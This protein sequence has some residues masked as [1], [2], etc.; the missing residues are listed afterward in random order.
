MEY[1]IIYG[2]I[3]FLCFAF[4]IFQKSSGVFLFLLAEYVLIGVISIICIY[5]GYV[6][7]ADIQLW[8]YLFLIIIYCI[9]LIPFKSLN[10]QKHKLVINCDD[11]IMRFFVLV[12]I[13]MSIIAVYVLWPYV[14]SLLVSKEWNTN[15][16]YL[17]TN[18]VAIVNN[19][20]EWVAINF[21]SYLQI[22]ALIVAF[23]FV[24]LNKYRTLRK[25]LF[26]SITTTVSMKAIYGSSRGIILDYLLLLIAMI[27]VF[28]K[29]MPLKKVLHLFT[30]VGIFSLL[31]LVYAIDVTVSRFGSR[32]QFGNNSSVGSL[33]YYF[34]HSPITFNIH[35]TRATDMM[36]GKFGFGPLLS[37]IGINDTFSK[38]ALGINWGSS[39]YTYVGYFYIDWGIVGTLALVIFLSYLM[40]MFIQSDTY[41]ISSLYTIF[42]Y[43]SFLEK[44]AFVIGRIFILEFMV[45]IIIYFLIYV[46]EYHI[47]YVENE[48]QISNCIYFK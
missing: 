14:S 42:F 36:L 1:T 7:A 8:P 35:I 16:D 39:F 44:G 47:V 2:A 33:L 38:K 45:Y 40:Y 4:F 10:E 22:P 13:A 6:D 48:K 25:I 24:C 34:G 37:Y 19:K 46:Y 12:Y 43:Y 30:A 29:W 18:D 20:L 23:I 9:S 21:T 31:T 17:Y 15:R 27:L 11:K 28:K 26:L 3:L 41:T 32:T 5:Y